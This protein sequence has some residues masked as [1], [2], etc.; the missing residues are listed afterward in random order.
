MHRQVR[1]L[2]AWSIKDNPK[3]KNKKQVAQLRFVRHVESRS[4]LLVHH[5]IYV[6][7]YASLLFSALDR[8]NA[9]QKWDLIS[10]RPEDSKIVFTLNTKQN[11][12][13][14]DGRFHA[15]LNHDSHYN[16]KDRT[17]CMQYHLAYEN[18]VLS[19]GLLCFASLT[20]T[21]YPSSAIF[22]CS[23]RTCHRNQIP[24]FSNLP[25]DL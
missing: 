13:R 15:A 9:T 5:H 6:I 7:K 19:H 22:R 2:H 16:A 3:T 17:T 12:A 21:T 25:H 11:N 4:Q 10:I 18:A 23:F 1:K 8:S 20:C 14:T 24:L